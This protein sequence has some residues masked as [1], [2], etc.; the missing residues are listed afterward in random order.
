MEIVSL[1]AARH[2][3]GRYLE[4]C[5]PTTGHYYESLD[6]RNLTVSHRL[7]Y[8]CP[9]VFE[10]GATIDF[11][12]ESLE[13]RQCLA[14][15]RDAGQ[16]YDIILVDPFHEYDTSYRDLREAFSLIDEGG[17]LVVHDCLPP[18]ASFASPKFVPGDWCGVTYKAYLDFV[19]ARNDLDYF[20]IDIDYGCGVI[21]KLDR[22]S[23]WRKWAQSMNPDAR[24]PADRQLWQQ[25]RDIG[26]D[27]ER[28]YGY[29]DEHKKRLLK[30][31]SPEEFF[32]IVPEIGDPV[33]S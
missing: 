12:S 18:N 11:R 24:R 3:F 33:G 16:F 1:L 5:T 8:N 7:M 2:G 17:M 14:E 10:D 27:F 28:A 20:T 29:F 4:L 32:A 6:R 23:R 21:R 13:I 22:L 19:R 9:V 15:M 25:W 31:I 30:L 26:N